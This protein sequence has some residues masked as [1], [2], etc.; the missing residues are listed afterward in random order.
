MNKTAS[1]APDPAAAPAKPDPAAAPAKPATPSKPTRAA[2]HP[3][4]IELVKPT[5]RKD[6]LTAFALLSILLAM[7][8]GFAQFNQTEAVFLVVANFVLPPLWACFDLTPGLT[9]KGVCPPQRKSMHPYLRGFMTTAAVLGLALP[10]VF[11]ILGSYPAQG[12]VYLLV[13]QI[14]GERIS[15]ALEW[16]AL[17]AYVCPTLM[18]AHRVW[19]SVRWTAK[20]VGPEVMV[21]ALNI[22]FWTFNLVYVLGYVNVLPLFRPTAR[23]RD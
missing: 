17:A 22:I 4:R 19:S 3:L 11:A 1:K 20:A 23:K 21:A 2:G 5:G 9:W 6:W 12:H 7:T 18:T 10:L 13:M 8:F 14:V 15:A 16:N